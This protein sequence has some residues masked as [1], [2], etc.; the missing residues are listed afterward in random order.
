MHSVVFGGF[1]ANELAT[2]IDDAT[3]KVIVSASCGIEVSKVIPY[4]PLLDAAIM[5]AVHKPERCIIL[6]RPLERAEL[7]PGATS[8]GRRRWRARSRHDCVPVRPPIRSTSSTPPARPASPRAWCATMAA[9]PWR[10]H[11]S[12]KNIYGMAPGEVY[13]GRLRR[14]LG[15][16]PF[17]H[18]LCAAALRLHDR[19]L[20]GQAGRHARCRRLLARDR[21]ST[22]CARSS[23][24]RP[25]SAPSSARIPRAS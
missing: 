2:R 5:M 21:R 12:M 20:R 25:P 18:R 23:P 9:M 24:R 8:I 7:I 4:K 3:P 1:A 6:Q 15:G 10:S 16:R 22:R 14:R 19:A 11:W 17:L 13:L